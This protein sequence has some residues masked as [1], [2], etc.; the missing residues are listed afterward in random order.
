[1]FLFYSNKTETLLWKEVLA[2]AFDENIADNDL[3]EVFHPVSK[4]QLP[5][6][7]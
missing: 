6:I 7:D 3:K 4:R 5:S 2:S 1:M